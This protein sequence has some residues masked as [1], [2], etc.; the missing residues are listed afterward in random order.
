MLF[1]QRIL[2]GVFQFPNCTHSEEQPPPDLLVHLSHCYFLL[3]S[4]R[5]VTSGPKMLT[6]FAWCVV[7]TSCGHSDFFKRNF[8]IN[9]N[10]LYKISNIKVFITLV[11]EL[12]PGD[13]KGY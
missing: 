9:N 5:K 3:I 10:E 1:S 7:T 6:G 13:E 2:R 12:V 4:M 11:C 8:L